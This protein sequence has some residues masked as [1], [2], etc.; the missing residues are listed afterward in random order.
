V[1]YINGISDWK[2][3]QKETKNMVAL[4]PNQKEYEMVLKKIRN[5]ISDRVSY[6]VSNKLRLLK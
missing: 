1:G 3:Q 4:F 6:I 5:L 2:L